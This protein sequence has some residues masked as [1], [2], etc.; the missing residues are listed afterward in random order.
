MKLSIEQF[1]KIFYRSVVDYHIK[2]DIYAEFNNP[3]DPQSFEAVLYLKNTI[4]TVQWHLEDLIREEN[5]EILK[6]L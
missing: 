4:D 3:Y 6:K 1:W 5:I 2:D